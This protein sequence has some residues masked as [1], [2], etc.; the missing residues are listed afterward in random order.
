MSLIKINRIGP[1]ICQVVLFTLD[2]RSKDSAGPRN[3]KKGRGAIRL[4]QIM[5]TMPRWF[6]FVE[7]SNTEDAGGVNEKQ[8]NQ[9]L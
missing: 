4:K 5:I 8:V 3:R 9:I 7:Q 6:Q 1:L 2:G